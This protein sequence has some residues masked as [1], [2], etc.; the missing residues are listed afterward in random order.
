MTTDLYGWSPRMQPLG[1]PLPGLAVLVLVPS[2]FVR[3]ESLPQISR[4]PPAQHDLE[5]HLHEFWEFLWECKGAYFM[6]KRDTTVVSA[7]IPSIDSKPSMVHSSIIQL[8]C[9][10]GQM[11][12]LILATTRPKI[13]PWLS[14]IE[15]QIR[16]EAYQLLY[17]RTMV[18]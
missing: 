14:S 5:G 3:H 18:D 13:H 1:F 2:V 4:T 7:S 16:V 12:D 11:L 8:D 17:N 15:L 10:S 6:L 9:W